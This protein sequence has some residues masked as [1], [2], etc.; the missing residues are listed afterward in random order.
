MGGPGGLSDSQ[1][2]QFGSHLNNQLQSHLG[3]GTS[4]GF[5]EIPRELARDQEAH[6]SAQSFGFHTAK[7]NFEAALCVLPKNVG[8]SQARASGG[9]EPDQ[10][11][12]PVAAID[13]DRNQP[14]H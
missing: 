11:I 5:F 14:E 4:D 12:S 10:S 3:F 7:S 6:R 8:F 9:S 2:Q 13:I 1:W